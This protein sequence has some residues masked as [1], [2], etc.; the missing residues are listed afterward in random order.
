MKQLLALLAA[1]TFAT[2]AFPWWEQ[3]HQ[4]V[5]LIAERNL[6]PEAAAH[7]KALLAIDPGHS[8]MASVA[9]W[10]DDL[11]EVHYH[12]G[13]LADD[14]LA[15]RISDAFPRNFEWHYMDQ[16]LGTTRYEL[17]GPFS[18]RSDPVH[19]LREAIAVLEGRSKSL[20]PEVALFMI[21][22]LVGDIHQPLHTAC[23]FFDITGPTPLLVAD[24][25]DAKARHLPTD[26]GGNALRSGPGPNTDLHARWDGFRP[27][28]FAGSKDPKAL[29]DKAAALVTPAE[30]RTAGDY[31]DWPAAW[32]TESIVLARSA[33]E[34]LSFGAV[35][36]GKD[37]GF[38]SISTVFPAD[39]LDA[40]KAQAGRQVGLAGYRL[41]DLL[42]SIAWG[43]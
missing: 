4:A 9:V 34:G 22:H 19:M 27:E 43:V 33:Y 18:N 36:P 25:A 32:A 7:V 12:K 8:D 15:H 3:G 20:P 14:P 37:G 2:P 38:R 6:T 31:H 29:A 21:V 11:R 1:L 26:M 30:A 24:P 42:N 28:A 13:R 10:L 41:A 17:D 5:A 35:K 23:G 16:P 39:Y 40:H